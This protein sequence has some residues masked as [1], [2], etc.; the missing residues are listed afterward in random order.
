MEN[1]ALLMN[2]YENSVRTNPEK[3]A[4]VDLSF[5]APVVLNYAEL[6]DWVD[7]VSTQ[8]LI[9]G[10]ESGDF[11]AYQLPNGWEFI[12]LTLALWKIGGVPCPL[13][14]SLRE[15]EVKFMLE[16]SRSRIFVITDEFRGFRYQEM[17]ERVKAELSQPLQI[18]TLSSEQREPS[19]S[20]FDGLAARE[21]NF[22]AI[23]ERKPGPETHAQLLYTSGTT[24][25]PKGVLHTHETLSRALHMH[26]QTLGLTAED[27]IWIP[28]PVAH[29]T[30]FLY[31]MAL[32]LYTGATGIYQCL[33][34]VEVAKSAIETYGAR[35]VQAAMPF[36]RDLTYCDHPPI[37]LKT[38]V[39]TGSAIPRPLSNEARK[40]LKCSII[41]GWGSTEACL[42]TVGR[43]SDPDDKKWGT[44]GRVIDHMRIRIVDNTGKEVPPGTE[45]HFQVQ[46]PAM[47]VDYLHH[48]EWYEEAF[49]ADK[50]MKTGDLAVI[51]QD[52]YLK[53]TGRLKDVINRGGE[54][55]PVVEIE[56]LLYQH[57][58]IQD[59]AI[60]A[61]PD[62]RLGERACAFVVAAEG[63][64][65]IN[66]STLTRWLE[67]SGTAKI[68]WPERIELIES[69]PRTPSGKVKKY[70]L[71]ELVTQKITQTSTA[72]N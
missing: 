41:G 57:P 70:L 69:L 37:G 21:I 12:V 51:D 50:Y 26:T 48:Q 36:L 38:F 42:V 9:L 22:K 64:V 23:H 11:V 2:K 46:T 20:D 56:D 55:V 30:G 24:G 8:L 67:Q 65:E 62:E 54:K 40:A 5:S 29:Q 35:F 19:T 71:R 1:V 10:L 66:L 45:G 52:G 53:I 3:Q 33:W 25:E 4:V 6:N 63:E 18:F 16:S 59:I 32:S 15:R 58:G 47:F 7:R 14:P 61:M 17:A 28:S 27:P 60:V 31:G 39:A 72:M 43:P 13:L 68:Y 34:D 44:D 49:T